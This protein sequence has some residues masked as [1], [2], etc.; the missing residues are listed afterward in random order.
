MGVPEGKERDKGA[1]DIFEDIM[2]ENLPKLGKELDIQVR[3]MLPPKPKAA[4]DLFRP[5]FFIG[6]NRYTI[7]SFTIP[8]HYEGS[9]NILHTTRPLSFLEVKGL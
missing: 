1:E 5:T 4:H 7:L 9:L 2:A 6:E 8:S 3:N